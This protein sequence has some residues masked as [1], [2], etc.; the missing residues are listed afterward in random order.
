LSNVSDPGA[1]E[2]VEPLLQV[3]VVRAE[4]GTAAI[5]IAGAIMETNSE[6][7]KKAMNKLLAVSGEE[8]LRKRAEEIVRQIKELETKTRQ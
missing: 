6:R 3:E 4:A 8:D 2:M 5:K 7:A 1:L